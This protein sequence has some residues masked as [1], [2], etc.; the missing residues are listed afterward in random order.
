MPT[1][2][3]AAK[4]DSL[5]GRFGRRARCRQALAIVTLITAIVGAGAA[6]AALAQDR[7][8]LDRQH[9][10]LRRTHETLVQESEQAAQRLLSGVERDV[11]TR[12]QELGRKLKAWTEDITD[13]TIADLQRATQEAL[14]IAEANGLDV[15]RLTRIHELTRKVIRGADF[16][17]GQTP[18][19]VLGS[20]LAQRLTDTLL[21]AIGEEDIFAQAARRHQ[22]YRVG[23]YKRAM[24]AYL[25]ALLTA[26]KEL[27]A[28][29]TGTGGRIARV[30]GQQVSLVGCH[31]PVVEELSRY[32]DA[33]RTIQ[34]ADTDALLA[35]AEELVAEQQ[36]VA[37]VAAGI[38]AVGDALDIYAVYSGENLAGAPLGPG[39]RSFTALMVLVPNVGPHIFEQAMKR[40]PRARAAAETIGAWWQAAKDTAVLIKDVYV[41]ET[42]EIAKDMAEAMAR[43]WGATVQQLEEMAGRLTSSRRTVQALTDAERDQLRIY[44]A[45]RDAA[46]DKIDIA[47][48]PAAYR[49]RARASAAHR[50]AL[51]VGAAQ[52]EA[53]ADRIRRSGLVPRHTSALADAARET[54]QI[55]IFRPVNPHATELIEAG[56]HTKPMGIKMKSA[57]VGAIAG[58]LPVNQS[59]NKT[60]TAL[61]EA[62][63]A[64]RRGAGDANQLRKD[65]AKL[66]GKLKE[67]EELLA[68]CFKSS[69]PCAKEIPHPSGV[70][71]A[72]DAAT[73]EA[74]LVF[75]DGRGG[76]IDAET[77]TPVGVKGTPK[78]AMILADPATG[79][80]L[81]ADYDL[82]AFG[83]QQKL[84][85][86]R[87]NAE[88]GFITDAQR[89]TLDDINER[90]RRQAEARGVDGPNVVH[91]GAE[92]NFPRSPGVDY[93]LTAFEPNGQMITIP[94][95]D[96]RCM[97][98]W[99]EVTK[100]CD[101]GMVPGRIPVD[102]DRLLKDYFHDKRHQ[103]FN[104]YPNPAW[105]WGAYNALG[106]WLPFGGHVPGMGR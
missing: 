35:E 18:K 46:Q 15:K 67:G 96:E 74:A 99:C 38:P 47:A 32:L 20:L 4:A 13:P 19:P 104:V 75:P 92:Q 53:L 91:H 11:E 97:K 50:A 58:A 31:D 84:T 87:H 52:A 63:E 3:W 6:G 80:P 66:E 85:A 1:F 57:E 79:K 81:T 62:R 70:L 71:E 25:R 10:A 39:E 86:P 82:L 68:K 43:R 88:T 33:V 56:Y 23:L 98:R 45:L 83:D 37:D 16:A 76:F 72:T 14:R 49:Q 22:E 44:Q 100:L 54:N 90:V 105:G 69:P 34:S 27:S 65:I 60:G 101:P 2:A 103:G 21:W 94:E 78:P 42:R 102:K 12:R 30:R 77:R 29:C 8:A 41:R 24:G 51:T 73:G 93:P 48:L 61:K 26:P 95:C 28:G 89:K 55:L 7:S 64:L 17:V 40:S 9:E 59:L 5:R 36:L 106:G